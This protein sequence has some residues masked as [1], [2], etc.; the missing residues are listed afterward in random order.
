MK[1]AVA[2]LIMLFQSQRPDVHVTSLE[3]AVF[4]QVNAERIRARLPALQLDPR[5][6]DIA[7]AHSEDMARNN[8]V[9]HINP[10]GQTP[11]DRLKA[12]GKSCMFVAENIYQNNLYHR[13][14]P[15]AAQIVYEWN[16]ESKI[17]MSSVR[18]WMDSPGHR[19]N[20]LSSRAAK[21]GLGVAIGGDLKVYITQEF[22]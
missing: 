9:A 19:V 6:S 3:K 14:L 7:R 22:C 2:L 5:L 21:T 18:G 11:M 16:S 17:A 10:A 8:F 13:A 4:E 1:L 15:V 12:A 20:I